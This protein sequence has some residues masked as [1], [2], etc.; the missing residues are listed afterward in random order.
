[1]SLGP[2]GPNS[3]FILAFHTPIGSDPCPTR[4]LAD[5]PGLQHQGKLVQVGRAVTVRL[6]RSGREAWHLTASA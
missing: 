6:P 3:C 5:H 2:T 1:M 4:H